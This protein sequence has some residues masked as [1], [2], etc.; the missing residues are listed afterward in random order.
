MLAS[1]RNVPFLI[2]DGTNDELV[3]VAGVLA[4]AQT[5]DDLGYRYAF[6]LFLPPVDHFLLAVN[7]QYAPAAKFLGNARVKRNPAHVTYA[8]NPTMDFKR[9]GTV[10][11]HAYW[12]SDLRL[13]DSGGSAPLGTIDARSEGFGVGDA[14]QKATSHTVGT[15]TGGNLGSLDYSEQAREWG[16]APAAPRRD[17]LRINATNIRRVTVNY[18]R[19]RLDCNVTVK[20]HSDG[21]LVIRLPGCDRAVHVH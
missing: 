1:V 8:V 12:L 9:D 20:S 13:R 16:K 17:V 19:A 15:L 7:D 4:Q 10:A 21:P 6:D 14:P 3:P 2:W 5:F 11:D 18:K